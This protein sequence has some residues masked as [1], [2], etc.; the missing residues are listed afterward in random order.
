MASQ[1]KTR[2]DTCPVCNSKFQ[3][4]SNARKYCSEKCGTKVRND[5]KRRSMPNRKIQ[6]ATCESIF[7]SKRSNAKYCSD[8]CRPNKNRARKTDRICKT[9]GRVFCDVGDKKYCSFGCRNKAYE[10]KYYTP[11][12][13]TEHNKVCVVCDK[14]FIAKYSHVKY[15]SKYCRDHAYELT[16]MCCQK[17]FYGGS[18]EIK[19][20]SVDCRVRYR[21]LREKERAVHKIQIDPYVPTD[22]KIPNGYYVYLWMDKNCL[23]YVGKGIGRRAW[24]RHIT[25]KGIDSR[26][27][28]CEKRRSVATD[29]RV[30]IA[31]D[32]L[33]DEGARLLES[34][35]IDLY[36][37]ECNQMD[38]IHRQE[39][40]P[41]IMR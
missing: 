22:T 30:I 24:E 9:C 40:P 1:V 27:A 4:T 6:C 20:C 8:K 28:D 25:G 16:C 17:K 31:R 21:T 38:G 13:P 35:F 41:L 32:N 23:F 18:K 33:T 37:P 36:R 5:K 12:T 10:A 29:F 39:K 11:T 2:T 7:Y 15:C 14:V 19:Y 3:T 26:S 34:V